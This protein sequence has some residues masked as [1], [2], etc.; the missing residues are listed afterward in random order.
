M[1]VVIT[2]S[3]TSISLSW[4]PTVQFANIPTSLSSVA[5]AL[6]LQKMFGSTS[7][8][9]GLCSACVQPMP[10]D[11]FLFASRVMTSNIIVRGTSYIDNPLRRILVPRVGQKVVIKY[12]GSTPTSITVYGAARL[13]GDHIHGFKALEIIYKKETKFIDVTI[14]EER[15]G[16]S[17][18]LSLQFVYKP[19]QGFA[20]IHEIDTGRNERIKAF[21]WQLWYGDNE[22]LPTIDIWDKFV[23]PEVT[24]LAEDVEQ[25]CAVVGNQ[26]AHFKTVRET[27]TCKRRWI[28]RL[29]R[30]GRCVFSLFFF[31]F[32]N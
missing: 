5:K 31:L 18:S 11:G 22:V 19:S 28:L 17:I 20:P 30:V 21:Y 10:F 7:Q 6:G 23:G 14:F 27:R 3:K 26:S 25:F 16:S 29:L 12:T 13:F 24:I 4:Q 15:Q 9:T 8:V 2:Y 32:R 1:R